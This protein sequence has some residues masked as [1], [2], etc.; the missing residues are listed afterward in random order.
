[1][2]SVFTDKNKKPTALQLKKALAKSFILWQT[3]ADFTR[4]SYPG[5]TEK[6]NY[7]GEKY[8]WNFLIR[9]KKR[10]L[11]YLLPCDGFFK[12]AFAFGQRATNEILESDVSDDIKS[13]IKSAKV[14]AEGRVIRI[15]VRNKAIL[16]D[17]KRLVTIKLAN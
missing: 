11:I 6:W 8:G 9:D 12:A 17:I 10:V 14:Y 15:E 2:K 4:T 5:A 3:L 1:M 7:S 16:N 13:E